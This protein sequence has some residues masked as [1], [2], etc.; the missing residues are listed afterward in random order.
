MR[1]ALIV[2]LLAGCSTTP[3]IHG[4]IDTAAEAGTK[5]AD[6]SRE[7]AEFVLCRGMSIGAW[8]RRYGQNKALADA[9]R[10]ICGTQVQE[11]P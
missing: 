9:W 6:D 7:A 10:V 3:A 5:A 4:S 8:V 2:L 11:T 1:R